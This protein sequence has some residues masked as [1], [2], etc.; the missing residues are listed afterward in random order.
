VLDADIWGFSIPRM[1][2]VKAR[3]AGT[4][5]PDG[6]GK[7]LPNELEVAGGGTLKIVSMDCSSTTR[8]PR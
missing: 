6:T 1:L 2:G 4:K 7:I 5:Q 8:T 3:L